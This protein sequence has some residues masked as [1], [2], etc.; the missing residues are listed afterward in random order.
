MTEK[1][2]FDQITLEQIEKQIVSKRG[3]DFVSG[4]PSH[5]DNCNSIVEIS[6]FNCEVDL[7]RLNTSKNRIFFEKCTLLNKVHRLGVNELYIDTCRVRS[8]QFI[9]ASIKALH[10]YRDYQEHM[11]LAEYVSLT[12]IIDDL[13]DAILVSIEDAWCELKTYSQPKIN[14][15]QIRNWMLQ[16]NRQISFKFFTNVQ[17]YTVEDEPNTLI[18]YKTHRQKYD[19]NIVLSSELKRKINCQIQSLLKSVQLFK[20]QLMHIVQILLFEVGIE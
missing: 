14:C 12:T 20:N 11:N 19:Q 18:K 5:K 13:S 7:S 3:H 9:G 17:D 4:F 6:I 8:S 15:L 16:I 2:I 1:D 10:I